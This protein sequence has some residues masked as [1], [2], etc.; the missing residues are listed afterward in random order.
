MEI[1]VQGS[2][3]GFSL[4]N[5][6]GIVKMMAGKSREK[7]TDEGS[8]FTLVEI[9]VSVAILALVASVTFAIV[10]GAVK[11]SR[12]ID[13]DLQLDNEASSIL[14]L[15]IEDIRGACLLDGTV[16]YFRGED[17]FLADMPTDRVGL[18]TS[19]VLPVSPTAA[20]GSFGEVE[21]FT[22]GGEDG[23]LIL[24][25]REQSPGSPPYDE[26]GE[27]VQVTDR[28]VFFDINYSDGEQW[29][30]E[31]DATSESGTGSGTLPKKVRVTLSL[32]EES[33]SV[34]RTAVVAPVMS[35]GR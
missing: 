15:V 18:L 5:V 20:R 27:T 35:V 26:G 29:Y 10:F 3:A 31:W 13:I 17:R 4:Y 14:A 25:R 6:Y 16:P 2:K 32:E 24:F 8:G 12:F 28:L 23:N 9:M 1:G 21:Y 34:T 19:A 33:L 7:T 30:E 22:S 11:R